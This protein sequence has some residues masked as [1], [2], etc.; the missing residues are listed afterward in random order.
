MRVRSSM[1]RILIACNFRAIYR[2]QPLI[3][4]ASRL[5]KGALT[6]K[7]VIIKCQ[8]LSVLNEFCIVFVFLF[9]FFSL[10]LFVGLAM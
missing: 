3:L 9:S 8:R 2:S 6:L 5:A 7:T 4:R 1:F 10:V